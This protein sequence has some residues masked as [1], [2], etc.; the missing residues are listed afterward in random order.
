MS[1]IET[2]T[3]FSQDEW[4]RASDLAVELLVALGPQEQQGC[5]NCNPPRILKPNYEMK[6]A[7][8]HALRRH[9]PRPEG[10]GISEKD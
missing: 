6:Y 1:E 2:W 9:P 3:E 5:Q 4:Q 7:L 10:R 8:A